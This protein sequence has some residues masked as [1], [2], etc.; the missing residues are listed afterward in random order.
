VTVKGRDLAE[1]RFWLFGIP[2]SECRGRGTHSNVPP[3]NELLRA[4]ATIEGQ[5]VAF[6]CSDG[7]TIGG[8]LWRAPGAPAGAVLVNPATGVLARYYHRYARFLAQHGFDVLTYDYRGIGASRP[9]RLRG[10]GYRWRDWG[11]RDF[12]AALRFV[13]AYRRSEPLL[14][15]GHSI[16][17]FLPGLAA[18]A[19]LIDRMLTVGAQYAWWRDYAPE[20]RV[21]LF[22]KWHIAMPAMTALCGYF[23]GRRLGWLED[24]PAGVANEWSF[25][26]PRFE[27]SHPVQERQAVLARVANVRAAILAVSVSDDEFGTLPAVRR[28]L[29]YYSGAARTLVQLTPTVY[30]REAIG[31]FSLFHDSFADTFWVDT[32]A[33]LRDGTN[34]WPHAVVP[35]D[36]TQP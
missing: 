7:V 25:R 6:T 10:C 24:L 18:N 17:G 14:V 35:L 15:V 27:R 33:W 21:P 16:G 20:R 32:L 1:D 5:P 34:P 29:R 9:D 28:A 12:S 31:H 30:G 26:G 23:P 13:D 11:E 2:T 3:M 8:H 4:T 22:L 19:R 36:D